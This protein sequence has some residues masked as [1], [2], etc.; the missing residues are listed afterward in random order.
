MKKLVLKNWVTNTLLTISCI[1]L[2]FMGS[3]CENFKTF[4]ISHFVA[5]GVFVICT[6]IIIKYGKR[7]IFN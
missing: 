1:A 5:L 2:L 3:D 4:I 7:E 6:I